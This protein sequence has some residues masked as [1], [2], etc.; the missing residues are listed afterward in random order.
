MKRTA[1]LLVCILAAYAY[2]Q[3]SPPFTTA[4]AKYTAIN[5]GTASNTDL[6]GSLTVLS[7]GTTSATPYTFSS[8]AARICTVNSQAMTAGAMAA[9]G[10]L[11]PQITATTLNIQF[12]NAVGANT[13][14]GYI[15][16]GTF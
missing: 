2:G 14:V 12:A 7:G 11:T 13:V 3:I 9:A 16:H 5:S 4:I 15:C 1:V 6:V 10:P 8:S